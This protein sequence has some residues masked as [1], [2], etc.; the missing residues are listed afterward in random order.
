MSS[1]C[2]TSVFQ[3]VSESRLATKIVVQLPNNGLFSEVS[4]SRLIES[5][6]KYVKSGNQKDKKVRTKLARI[7]PEYRIHQWPPL[8]CASLP[9]IP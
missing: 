1:R 4:I 2:Q 8:S 6:S 5:P 7:E 9:R 3:D